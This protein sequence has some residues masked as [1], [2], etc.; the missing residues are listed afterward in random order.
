NTTQEITGG[1]RVLKGTYKMSYGV[2]SLFSFKEPK[3]ERGTERT[4]FMKAF[5]NVEQLANSLKFQVQELD[6]TFLSQSDIQINPGD[7]QLDSHRPGDSQLASI[8]RLRPKSI[9]VITDAMN[10]TVKLNVNA[11][12]ESISRSAVKAE[13]ASLMAEQVRAGKFDVDYINGLTAEF[14]RMY[15]LNA[16]IERLVAQHVFTDAIHAKS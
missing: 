5:S 14:Q 7:V 13:F 15:T 4:P 6:G 8:L 16:N 12:M 11:E 2:D 10:L 3:L 9:D 1:T